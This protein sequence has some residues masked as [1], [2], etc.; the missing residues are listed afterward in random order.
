[1]NDQR[2]YWLDEPRNV[3]RV[4]WGLAAV[5]ALLVV[6]GLFVEHHA[7]FGWER[8]PGAYAVF[9]F[10][11]FFAIVMAGKYLRLLLRRDED[12]YDR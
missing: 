11:A 6:L 2:R 12:Y 1:M 10:V 3:S 5:C 8:W 4:F 9:G 7:H